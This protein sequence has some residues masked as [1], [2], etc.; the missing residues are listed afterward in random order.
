[1]ASC[2]EEHAVV[3]VDPDYSSSTN[4]WGVTHFATLSD[5]IEAVAD[6]GN[7]CVRGNAILPATIV[8]DRVVHVLGS[9]GVTL[10]GEALDGPLFLV[11]RGNTLTLSDLALSCRGYGIVS[12]SGAVRMERCEV[13]GARHAGLVSLAFLSSASMHVRSSLFHHCSTGIAGIGTY[14]GDV[15]GAIE[16]ATISD[17]AYGIVGTSWPSSR[18]DMSIDSTSLSFNAKR[19]MSLPDATTT[20]THCLMWEN[21]DDE[22]VSSRY[23]VMM[24]D[25]LYATGYRPSLSSPLIDAGNP[26]RSGEQSLAGTV[27]PAGGGPD[28][29]AF[30]GGRHVLLHLAD[31][32]LL[33]PMGAT[34]YTAVNLEPRQ[35]DID[36]FLSTVAQT[37]PMELAVDTVVI[38]G[39][40][41]D[42][43]TTSS[44]YQTPLGSVT[45]EQW[46]DTY[47][48]YELFKERLAETFP[49]ASIYE[50]VG[51][52]DYR[53][54][55]FYPWLWGDD[56]GIDEAFRSAMNY[57][58]LG[59]VELSGSDDL[60]LVLLSS[61]H[62]ASRPDDLH[63]SVIYPYL[64]EHA[65]NGDEIVA[66]L[67]GQ[68]VPGGIEGFLGGL[69]YGS[70]FTDAQMDGLQDMIDE[71]PDATYVVACHYP[72]V[73]H[74]MTVTQNI[75]RFLDICRTQTYRAC[76]RATYTPRR[77]S[78]QHGGPGK[79]RRL[80]SQA[81]PRLDSMAISCYPLATYQ[82]LSRSTCTCPRI[83]HNQNSDGGTA[84][85]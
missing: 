79:R 73:Y 17:N 67:N 76:S 24:A 83:T 54:H 64:T 50:V 84:V 52:H 6:G 37:A 4:G 35:W 81:Q 45:R 36:A 48:G 41:V 27:R 57:A 70:G 72:V 53:E 15:G 32:H 8:I 28:I 61:G 14:I 3:Y 11:T 40:L 65:E 62:D 82:P 44:T 80:S 55:P 59:V 12:V 26:L 33:A 46:D 5:A 43:A 31:L 2:S 29:G 21:G 85:I 49:D 7:V 77:Q 66:Y 78:R 38:T 58:P 9:D 56:V 16:G 23:D 18:C 51:N 10:R 34:S 25:P 60:R 13:T 30:E 71:R 19:A 1:M 22:E 42:L 47:R 74:Q 63:A 69:A 20:L 75:P 39:D 68:T